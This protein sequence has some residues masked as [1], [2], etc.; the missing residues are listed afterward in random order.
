MLGTLLIIYGVVWAL[1][2]P[3]SW[4]PS[5]WERGHPSRR[6][7]KVDRLDVIYITLW[8][9]SLCVTAL[10]ASIFLGFYIKERCF[11]TRMGVL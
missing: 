2:I 9:I 1:W 3:Q 5:Q 8:P 10:A 11:P 4:I 7:R 6:P